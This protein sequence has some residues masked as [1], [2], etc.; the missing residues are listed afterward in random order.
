MMLVP[1]AAMV[2]QDK[3]PAYAAAGDEAPY[4]DKVRQKLPGTIR[5][6]DVHPR[7]LQ[8]GNS[9]FFTEPIIIGPRPAPIT[10]I[11]AVQ[12]HGGSSRW[13]R[14]ISAFSA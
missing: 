14:K 11:G 5:F 2:L 1:T 4:V 12:A 9:L 7:C 13:T 10:P 6:V 8:N 3:L